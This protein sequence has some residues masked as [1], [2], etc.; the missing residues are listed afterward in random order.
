MNINGVH[1]LKTVLVSTIFTAVALSV[2]AYFSSIFSRSSTGLLGSESSFWFFAVLA[3]FVD[4]VILGLISG[5]VFSVIG[6]D[7]TKAV[8]FSTVFNVLVVAVFYVVFSNGGI[9]SDGIRY[10]L[11]SLIPIG[12]LNAVIA[13]LIG[14]TN[15]PK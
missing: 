1:T 12:I 6:P 9:E 11:Y 14:S 8:L 2:A 15:L 10:T 3:G 13:S 7:T 5:V 4:G